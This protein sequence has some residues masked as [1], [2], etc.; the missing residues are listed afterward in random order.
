MEMSTRKLQ[1]NAKKRTQQTN[2]GTKATQR[3]ALQNI[4]ET[5][6]YRKTLSKEEK[7]KMTKPS[8]EMYNKMAQYD[9]LFL[10]GEENV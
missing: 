10:R 2:T 3:K 1:S 4:K 7:D 8:K 6:E 5:K 9:K